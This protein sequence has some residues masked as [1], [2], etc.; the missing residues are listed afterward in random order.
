MSALAFS[1]KAF[2]FSS[3]VILSSNSFT[4]VSSTLAFC[5][6]YKLIKSAFKNSS[7]CLS[8][9]PVS[10]NPAMRWTFFKVPSVPLPNPPSGC[11]SFLKE[12]LLISASISAESWQSLHCSFLTSSPLSPYLSSFVN[13]I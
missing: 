11:P 13:R 12:W 8:S 10:A 6:L 9:F 4:F 2:S 3:F 1:S 5:C 7:V